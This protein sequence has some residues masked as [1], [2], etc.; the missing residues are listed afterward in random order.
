MDRY[1]EIKAVFLALHKRG[2]L[3]YIDF[4]AELSNYLINSNY[5]PAEFKG[6][7]TYGEVVNSDKFAEIVRTIMDDY[8]DKLEWREVNDVW[9]YMGRYYEEEENE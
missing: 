4:M 8:F 9:D 2:L 5:T 3:K 7:R 1:E 6:M